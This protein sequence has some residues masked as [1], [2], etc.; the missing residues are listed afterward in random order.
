VR[1]VRTIG[2]GLAALLLAACGSA[3]DHA[4]AGEGGAR[5]V[6]VAHDVV[7]Q[8][9][10]IARE[11][12]KFDVIA[13]SDAPSVPYPAPHSG[14]PVALF[15]GGPI[16]DRPTIV[17]IFFEH[18][19]MQAQIESFLGQLSASSYWPAVATE[20]GAGPLAIAPSI[21]VT[22]PVPVAIEDP[23]IASWLAAYL[24]GTHP[25]WPPVTLN[26]IYMVFYPSRTTIT[27]PPSQ[28]SCSSFGGYHYQ[29]KEPLRPTPMDGGATAEGGD[30]GAAHEGGARD[31]G[32]AEGG[33]DAGTVPFVYSVIPRCATFAEHKGI[34]AVT[35][36]ISHEAVEAATDP[37]GITEPA[38]QGVDSDHIVW[39]VDPGGEIGDLCAYEPQ[40]F[41]RLVGS[42]LVQRI[43]S[44]KAAAAG[45]D[46]C[47]PELAPGTPYFNTSP[48]LNE[49]V[50]LI[51]G[52]H[53]PTK[54]IQIPVGQKKTI[55]L[56]LFSTAPT[57]NWNV[58]L[59]DTS[60]AFG[61]SKLLDFSPSTVAGH[62]GDVVSVEITAVAPGPLGGAEF[63]IYSY[64]DATKYENFWFGFV[65]N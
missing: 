64:R 50:E 2:A 29:G 40:S 28:T 54:G 41:Q 55:A 44:K 46:P 60:A 31:A 27:I 14:P 32:A 9:D 7:P 20:Y 21:V 33:V 25:E 53:Y 5:D 47:V 4:D 37:L 57:E 38:Y 18:D 56:R 42:F 63:L 45:N 62:N 39:E 26:N 15:S 1:G 17:P 30:G 58:Y 8:P 10:V 48:D 19:P 24:D 12:G 61:G 6:G 51:D 34:D 49:S 59:V 11:S 52:A 22:D 3:E 13:H 23:Q 65:E 36:A 43:W 16:L 35:S